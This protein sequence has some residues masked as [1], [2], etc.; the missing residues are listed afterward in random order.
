M[1]DAV[2][3]HHRQDCPRQ[4]LVNE[5][6]S[7]RRLHGSLMPRI[8]VLAVVLVPLEARAHVVQCVL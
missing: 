6:Q 8:H 4:F 1:N 7:G 2:R 5:K 3:G